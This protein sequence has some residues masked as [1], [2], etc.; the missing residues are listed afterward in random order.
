MDVPSDPQPEA[1]ARRVLVKLS[2]ELLAGSQ[3]TPV[4]PAGLA[5]VADQIAG[6]H[7]TGAE[8]AVVLGGGNIVRGRGSLG[9]RFDRATVDTIGMAG[10]L[11]N[12][13]AVQAELL[14]RELPARVFNAFDVPRLAELYSPAAAQRALARGAVAILSGGT[15]NTH[16]TTDTAAALRALE[17]HCTLLI[18]ATK[19]DGVYSADPLREPAA[20]RFARLTFEEVLARKLGVMDLTAITLCMENA[21]PVVVLN[22]KDAGSVRAYLQGAS[23]GTLIVPSE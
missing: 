6:A 9:D 11:V 12:A 8:V 1:L 2:G 13:L 5:W 3:G 21:L 17:T 19:V 4:D 23:L 7:A 14:R 10:T 18:K 15:G 20:Q 16:F 22:A